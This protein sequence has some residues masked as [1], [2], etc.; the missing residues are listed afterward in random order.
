MA[1][2]R[3]FWSETQQILLA[4]LIER[5][6]RPNAGVGKEKIAAAE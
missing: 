2:A 4:L 3:K 6:I 5:D 1:A